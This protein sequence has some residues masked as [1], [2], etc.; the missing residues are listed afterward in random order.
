MNREVFLIVGLGNPGEEHAHTR[1]NAGFDTA[2]RL[3]KRWNLTLR[4]KLL[5]RGETA[6]TTDGEKKIVLC[7]PLTYMNASGECVKRLMRW[8]DCPADHLLVIYDD[9]DLAPGRLRMRRGGG[10]GTHN[11]MRSIVEELGTQ[12]FPR[13]RIG[14]GD[15]PAGQDLVSWVL[16]RFPAEERPMMEQTFELAAEC[17]EDWVRNGLDHATQKAATESK[18]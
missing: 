11:G 13:L 6:E 17:A 3:E 15:R 4:R 1:H 10:P 5:L 2:E 14:T 7:R 12:D 18:R 16:G 8:Y 9:I